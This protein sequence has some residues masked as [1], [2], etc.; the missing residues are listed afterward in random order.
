MII[1]ICRSCPPKTYHLWDNVGS[2]NLHQQRQSGCLDDLGAMYHSAEHSILSLDGILEHRVSS[3][4]SFLLVS[5]VHHKTQYQWTGLLSVKRKTIRPRLIILSHRCFAVE[6]HTP[7][8]ES[9]HIT[10]AVVSSRTPMRAYQTRLQIHSGL[11]QGRQL[12]WPVSSCQRSFESPEL[13]SREVSTPQYHGGACYPD[14]VPQRSHRS[15]LW[16]D[17]TLSSQLVPVCRSFSKSMQHLGC[18]QILPQLLLRGWVSV[19][20]ISY[21]ILLFS[22]IRPVT[23]WANVGRRVLSWFQQSWISSLNLAGISGP[24]TGLFPATTF[25]A[26]VHTII[27]IVRIFSFFPNGRLPGVPAHGRTMVASSHRITPK[28]IRRETKKSIGS[29]VRLHIFV[30]ENISRAIKAAVCFHDD[31][32]CHIG[33]SSN[34]IGW[35]LQVTCPCQTKVYIGLFQSRRGGGGGVSYLLP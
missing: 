8:N 32:R 6:K 18:E 20:S 4:H 11:G 10:E 2:H 28:L 21:G 7:L 16:I 26:I 23:I 25:S 9:K 22:S 14:P 17:S 29:C 15:L 27:N 5:T 33:K 30:P 24:I 12:I 13:P 19:L 31:F 3:I 35:F 34:V 1:I